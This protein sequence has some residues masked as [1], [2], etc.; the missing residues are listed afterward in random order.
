MPARLASSI[1][2][3]LAATAAGYLTSQQ[4]TSDTAPQAP[5]PPPPPKPAPLPTTPTPTPEPLPS[6]E[7]VSQITDPGD[8]TKAV[9][10]ILPDLARTDPDTAVALV[11]SLKDITSSYITSAITR[12]A[13]T[14]PTLAADLAA[15]IYQ[16]HPN[17]P[18]HIGTSLL[19][20][21]FYRDPDAAIAIMVDWPAENMA[22]SYFM[23]A[24]RYIP[25]AHYEAIGTAFLDSGKEHLVKAFAG[26]LLPLLARSDPEAARRWVDATA[27]AFPDSNRNYFPEYAAAQAAASADIPALISEVLAQPDPQFRGTTASAVAEQLLE[28]GHLEPAIELVEHPSVPHYT[29]SGFARAWAQNDPDT[30]IA[31]AN[32]IQD[33]SRR[34]Q[35]HRAI[36]STL[37][38]I[39]PERLGSLEP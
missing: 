22:E 20:P 4:L 38:S 8:K 33:Q 14:N 15:Q 19:T 36:R 18:F 10:K 35:V 30:A 1:L 34:K 11:R 24:D 23:N 27:D 13:E 9:A 32:A 37:K 2:T 21:L 7:Q 6:P 12:V 31:W 25:A 39:D 3:L 17:A 28:V 29:I 5:T 16:D 26:D